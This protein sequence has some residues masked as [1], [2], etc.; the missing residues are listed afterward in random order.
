MLEKVFYPLSHEFLLEHNGRA[1]DH[2]WANWDLC[3]I[4]A[5]QAI[6]VLSDNSSMYD[7]AVDYYKNGA[8]NGQLEKAIWRL[9]DDSDVPEKKLGQCQES[10]RD[11]D[12]AML[13]FALHG[14]VAQQAWPQGDD[15][16]GAL[17]SRILAG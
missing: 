8:G 15:L 9:Y 13:N 7:E 5:I 3:N 1:I 10:G 16:F 2:Y 6:D 4:A 17:D 11:Q 12:H 14:V